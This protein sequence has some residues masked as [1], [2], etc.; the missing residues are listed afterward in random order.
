MP[1]SRA[2]KLFAFQVLAYAVLSKY[3]WI[4]ELRHIV[5]MESS[6][7]FVAYV[8][9][10]LSCAFSLLLLRL[11]GNAR[12]I[13]LDP[14]P[15]HWKSIWALAVT[16]SICLLQLVWA[17]GL[18]WDLE[19]LGPGILLLWLGQMI[20]LAL[21]EEIISRG[22]ILR[23]L[24]PYGRRKAVI[25][26]ALLFMTMHL[27]VLAWRG[28]SIAQWI[29]NYV[30]IGGLGYG[31][32]VVRLRTRALIPIAIIHGVWNFLATSTNFCEINPCSGPVSWS[33]MVTIA[34]MCFPAIVLLVFALVLQVTD[35]RR[36][37]A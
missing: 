30:T 13:D 31:L 36:K 32:A 12:E 34:R 33:F 27:P 2:A 19:L 26:S 25:L 10:I 11:T 24:A 7:L 37:Q 6:D 35:S 20:L 9:A 21:G 23:E 8:Q 4:N 22:L 17:T 5:G 29:V 28:G 18:R 16:A 14:C 3:G 15:F 1:L